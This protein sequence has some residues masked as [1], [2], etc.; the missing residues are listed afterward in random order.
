MIY[1]IYI[2]GIEEPL[3]TY[4]NRDLAYEAAKYAT[5]ETDVFHEVREVKQ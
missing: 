2:D 4:D 3:E 5:E 1:G